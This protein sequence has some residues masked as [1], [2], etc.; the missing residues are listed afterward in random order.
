MKL[1]A[2]VWLTCLLVPI[3]V[4]LAIVQDSPSQQGPPPALV[5][6]T[7]TAAAVR[8]G[9]ETRTDVL[10]LWNRNVRTSPI[11]HGIKACI[12]SGSGGILGNGLMSC[13]LTLMM[14]TGKITATG[15]VHDLGRYTLVITGGTGEYESVTGALFVR[16]VGDGV[17]RLTFTVA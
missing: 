11:G 1:A 17:R 14:P 3:A 2:A 7:I 9:G 15:P 4:A 10:L 5:S 16:R 6:I 8:D 13:S 12:K